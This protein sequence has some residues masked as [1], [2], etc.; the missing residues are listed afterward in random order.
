MYWFC[1]HQPES[2][3]GI[4]VFPIPN[5]E[6]TRRERDTCTPMFIAALFIIAR[7]WKQPRCPSADEWIRKLMLPFW[8]L[9]ILSYS[10]FNLSF[11]KEI[12]ITEIVLPMSLPSSKQLPVISARLSLNCTFP[13][14]PKIKNSCILCKGCIL[15]RL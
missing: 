12:N 2:A 10:F 6:K 15:E 8:S 9:W 4:H 5:P 7:T 13:Y 11:I 14:S 1:L 3:T